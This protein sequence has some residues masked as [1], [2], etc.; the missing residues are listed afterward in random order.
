MD[1][2]L[3]LCEVARAL[4]DDIF[5]TVGL[6]WVMPGRVIDFFAIWRGLYGKLQQYIWKMVPIRTA[7]GGK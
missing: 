4:W 6:A 3:F 1:S 7:N 5:S 2:F